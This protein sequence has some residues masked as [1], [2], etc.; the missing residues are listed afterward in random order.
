MRLNV[1]KN[2]KETNGQKYAFDPMIIRPSYMSKA[3]LKEIRER[4]RNNTR[5]LDQVL[6]RC[7]Y[8]TLFQDILNEKCTKGDLRCISFAWNE[9]V[10]PLQY[11]PSIFRLQTGNGLK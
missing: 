3:V 11:L 10:E 4:V 5:V 8:I 1:L 7:I 6:L 2:Y 9:V